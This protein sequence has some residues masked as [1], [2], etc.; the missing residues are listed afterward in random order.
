MDDKNFAT[1][2]AFNLDD[3][4][5]KYNPKKLKTVKNK[6]II[7][8]IVRDA[9]YLIV[10]DIIENN[11]TF[12]MPTGYKKCDIHVNSITGKN[13][14]KARQHGAFAD[15]DFLASNFTAHRLQLTIH[16]EDKLDKHK[17]IYVGW[18]LKKKL[19]DYTNQGRKYQ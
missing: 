17:N 2:Y 5:A 6:K 16:N 10:D 3:A 15:V 18:D 4:F 19:L 7:K 8:K 1:G 9:L 14:E 13:F 12:Q 11:V